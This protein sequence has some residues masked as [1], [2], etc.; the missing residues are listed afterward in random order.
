MS[1][2]I[3]V[4]EGL[5]LRLRAEPDAEAVFKVIDRNR[6]YLKQW[7]PWL[8]ESTTV[9]QT[10]KYIVSDALEFEKKEG[11]DLG[12]WF[13]NQWVGGI[14]YHAWGGKNRNSSIGYWLSEEFQGK[15]IMTDAVRALVT[16]GFE[17]MNLNRVEIH[18][19]TKNTKSRSIP[20][21]LGF[22]I[23]GT[24]RQA[25]WLYD[26]FVDLTVYSVLKNEWGVGK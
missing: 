2:I 1:I 12:I 20:E 19:A 24:L 10:R 16:Y 3:P 13:E 18:C 6:N 11:L 23:D 22:K 4:R 8:D 7:L 5:E 9:E 15:G 25:E 26:H 14:G 21:R 17:E